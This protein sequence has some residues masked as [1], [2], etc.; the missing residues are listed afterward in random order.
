MKTDLKGLLVE[1]KGEVG[2]KQIAIT[3]GVIIVIGVVVTYLKDGALVG[4]IDDIWTFL[5]EDLIK[6]MVS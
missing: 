1:E 3:V 6:K 2:I 4:W 5:F